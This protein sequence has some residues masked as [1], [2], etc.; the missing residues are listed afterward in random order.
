MW[1]SRPL[2]NESFEIFHFLAYPKYSESK[3]HNSLPGFPR[4]LDV[5]LMRSQRGRRQTQSNLRQIPTNGFPGETNASGFS[6]LFPYQGRG[7]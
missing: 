4:R 6:A 1:T 3:T 2:E 5:P 7:F